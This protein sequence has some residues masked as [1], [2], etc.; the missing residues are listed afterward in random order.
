MDVSGTKST[1]GEKENGPSSDQEAADGRCSCPAWKRIL[2][3]EYR[4][5][6][7]HLFKLAGPVV[8]V[9]FVRVVDLVG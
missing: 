9:C 4:R 8:S 7:K 5:E 6:L 3:L 2:P 1:E